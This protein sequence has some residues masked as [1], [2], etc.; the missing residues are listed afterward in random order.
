M[1]SPLA[2]R[3]AIPAGVV[4]MGDD[5]PLAYPEDG[6]TPRRTVS[7]APF[8][9]GRAPV[10]VERFAAFVDATG[11]VTDAER[12]GTS[13]VFAGHLPADHPPTRAVSGSPWWREVPGATWRSPTGPHGGSAGPG[14]HPVVHV[15]WHD[16]TAYAEWVGGRLPTEAEWEHAARAGTTTTYPW[17]EEL[18]PDGVHRA[19]LFQGWFPD[20]DTGEDG[21]VGTSPVGSFPPNGFGLHDVIGNVWEWTFDHF[22]ARATVRPGNRVHKG[23]SYLCHHSYCHR[24]RPGARSAAAERGSAG[25]AGFRV[26]WDPAD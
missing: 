25:N 20:Q 23:G 26:A 3:V 10:T 13:F 17:G 16:A 9:L 1:T 12:G 4:V 7:V 8:A 24:Y 15:S 22:V 19:N 11:H 21:W 6:E 14:D 18:T 5:G 2:D